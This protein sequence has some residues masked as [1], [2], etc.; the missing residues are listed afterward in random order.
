MGCHAIPTRYACP[1]KSFRYVSTSKKGSRSIGTMC[2]WNG[3]NNVI[4]EFERV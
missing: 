4:N 3:G 1:A 2:P